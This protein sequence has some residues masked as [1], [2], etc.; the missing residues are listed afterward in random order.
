MA[1]ACYVNESFYDIEYPCDV[2]TS[3]GTGD[4]D[5]IWDNGTWGDDTYQTYN[6]DGG[7][8]Y[9]T[10]EAGEPDEVGD[11]DETDENS[12]SNASKET[13]V[14][15][16]E[17]KPEQETPREYP[18][19]DEKEE[20]DEGNPEEEPGKEEPEEKPEVD[21]E[22]EPALIFGFDGPLYINPDNY[23]YAHGYY[24]AEDLEAAR[25]RLFLEGL[26]V[27]DENEAVQT[28][29]WVADFGGFNIGAE[30][31]TQFIITY[32]ARH[33]GGKVFTQ[34]REA[35]VI[36]G[37][38]TTSEVTV[39]TLGAL[40]NA[41]NGVGAANSANPLTV[42]IGASFSMGTGTVIVPVGRDITLISTPGNNFIL[43]SPTGAGTRHFEVRGVLR[44]ED[45][46]LQ[47][48]VGD[49]GTTINRGGVWV[50]GS[51]HLYIG[52]G[53]VIRNNRRTTG[54]GND[55]G[56]VAVTG[57]GQVTM[58][59]GRIHNNFS[60]PNNGDPRRGGGGVFMTNNAEFRMQGGQI[61]NNMYTGTVNWQGGGGVHL[62]G[63][64]TFT[65]D[66]SD[67]R[68]L[69]NT[70]NWD[71]GGVCITEHASF[72]M[73]AGHITGNTSS[74]SGHGGGGVFVQGGLF[75]TRNHSEDSGIVRTITGN[76]ANNGGGISVRRTFAGQFSSGR[77]E[78]IILDGTLIH[79]NTARLNNGGM[80][81]GI[82]L[83][84]DS[85]LTMSGGEISENNA[86]DGGGVYLFTPNSTFD[87]S[88]G[89]ISGHRVR[90]GGGVLISNGTFHINGGEI[91][92]NKADL[93]GGVYMS[94]GTFDMNNGEINSNGA[95][96]GGGVYLGGGTLN[97][98][99]G[100]ISGNDAQTSGG[101]IFVARSAGLS[102]QGGTI[103]GNQAPD[104]HGGGIF[105]EDVSYQNITTTSSVIFSENIAS[106]SQEFIG[107]ASNY[108]NIDWG[109]LSI[110]IGRTPHA[111]NNF[112]INHITPPFIGLM[113]APN[114]LL[115]HQANIQTV[116]TAN[117]LTNLVTTI[118]SWAGIPGFYAN[119]IVVKD[120]TGGVFN[121]NLSLTCTQELTHGTLALENAL[122]YR[123]G[124]T[125]LPFGL[126]DTITIFTHDDVYGGYA[127]LDWN[128]TVGI[129]LEEDLAIYLDNIIVGARY[130]AEFLWV[131]VHD[132]P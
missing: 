28:D 45:I 37:I 80:G 109:S 42:R 83:L 89:E 35:Y 31:G 69:G 38:Q 114:D 132:M 106:V 92:D 100:K 91:I 17:E 68:I 86:N 36:V 7:Y 61:S 72:I 121:W 95:N 15:D 60:A 67:A 130:Q 77:G 6:P 59:G 53:A 58:S 46:I 113:R 112:D 97:M 23:P 30:P 111:L 54:G 19:E 110:S 116:T 14:E 11:T 26:T 98:N 12:D 94:S 43:T 47:T 65:I 126:N 104:G 33:L 63:S 123:D 81:G 75:E 90:H 129:F 32:A 9:E 62:A 108:P 25:Q 128:D 29:I 21:A 55:G 120:T 107:I 40:T 118:R 56:G 70:S 105:T 39:T 41:I 8:E 48:T 88:G 119:D 103:S 78:A 74:N 24:Y 117:S 87:M 22:K 124:G 34:T 50:S 52:D 3:D 10:D 51:G 131:L 13:E 101:G 96:F 115:F 127:T 4:L 57:N 73:Y 44:L 16:G 79:D 85:I 82:F 64:S 122:V 27:T 49:P 18:E 71:A 125:V 1:S 93:G 2:N 102:A 99:S 20:H 76:T 66:G 5:D 84:Q